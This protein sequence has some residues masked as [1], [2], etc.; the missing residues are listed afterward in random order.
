MRLH[1]DRLEPRENPATLPTGYYEVP[2]AEGIQEGSGLLGG[3]NDA[4]VLEKTG[5]VKRF[6]RGST[7]ADV[8]LSIPVE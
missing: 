3:T 2:I 7:T 5:T 1:L 6:V 8:V 4:W